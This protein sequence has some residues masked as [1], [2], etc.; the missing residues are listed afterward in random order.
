MSHVAQ[1]IAGHIAGV[2]SG[3]AQ[4]GARHRCTAAEALGMLWQQKAPRQQVVQ[5]VPLLRKVHQP[6]AAGAPPAQALVEVQHA[7]VR[8]VR[9]ARHLHTHAHLLDRHLPSSEWLHSC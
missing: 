9:H 4:H 3:Q 7:C 1:S 5:L 2:A 6:Q 8:K